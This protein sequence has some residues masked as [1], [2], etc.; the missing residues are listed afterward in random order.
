MDRCWSNGRG[1]GNRMARQLISSERCRRLGRSGVSSRGRGQQAAGARGQLAAELPRSVLG[2]RAGRAARPGRRHADRDPLQGRRRSSTRATCSSRSTRAPTRSGWR[3]RMRS[4]R[5]RAR[6]LA[7]AERELKR[8]Q[9]LAAKA[10]SARSQNVDQRTADQRC[11]QAAI[12]TPRRRSATPSSTS[13]TAASRRRFTGRIGAHLVSV[14]NLITGS[15]AGNE[16][17]D[18]AGDDGLARS[19]PSR[20]RHERGR[21]PRLFAR[22]RAAQAAPLADKVA[23]S[24]SDETQ[25]ARQGTLDFVDN[26]LDRSQ[27]HDPRPRHRAQPRSHLHARAVRPP[28]RSPSARPRRPCWCRPRPSCR[29]SRSR[30]S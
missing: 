20:L 4:S 28:A 2:R 3:R 10:T 6:E 15:R 29:T 7:L 19:D 18:V 12:E 8:A 9:E 27:R 23:I 13:I 17:D 25:F 16:P 11:A 24:L 1:A 30:S 22:A 21:L 5:P 14:G 26:A